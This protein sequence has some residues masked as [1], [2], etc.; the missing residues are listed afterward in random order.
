MGFPTGTPNS[1][2]FRISVQNVLQSFFLSASAKRLHTPFHFSDSAF[3]TS[4]L[5]SFDLILDCL[6]KALDSSSC[7]H[8][9]ALMNKS[10]ASSLAL[11][12][13]ISLSGGVLSGPAP[14]FGPKVSAATSCI[15]GTISVHVISSVIASLS[16]FSY[17][18]LSSSVFSLVVS[19]P[20]VGNV[21]GCLH[22]P[23]LFTCPPVAKRKFIILAMWSVSPTA[24][25][26]SLPHLPT[27]FVVTK[28]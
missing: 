12:I 26:C 9:L 5:C 17:W 20:L 22:L 18:I 24:T 10:L 4:A 11:R 15:L 21:G 13:S 14:C 19:N 16:L 6:S 25:A 23:L 28:K 7:S 3:L 27:S 2:S 8:S 1:F